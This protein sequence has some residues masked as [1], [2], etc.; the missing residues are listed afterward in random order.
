MIPK[1]RENELERKIEHEKL[2]SHKPKQIW[3]KKN[4]IKKDDLKCFVIHTAQ[5]GK[6]LKM[7][8]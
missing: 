6:Y 4:W 8:S 1:D 2:K 3:V 5:S 7:V